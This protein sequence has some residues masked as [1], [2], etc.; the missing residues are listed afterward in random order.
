MAISATA[1]GKQSTVT[2][3]SVA[4]STTSAVSSS[5]QTTTVGNAAL[6]EDMFSISTLAYPVTEVSQEDS[7][8]VLS[9]LLGSYIDDSP[10][11]VDEY[12]YVKVYQ[13]ENGKFMFTWKSTAPSDYQPDYDISV[14]TVNSSKNAVLYID[15]PTTDI[16]DFMEPSE[17]VEVTQTGYDT[18]GHY[19]F[20]CNF[21]DG[22]S[23]NFRYIA[24]S[25]LQKMIDDYQAML[26]ARKA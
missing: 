10:I 17:D 12:Q 22:T 19:T 18:S 16:P 23:G 26:D 4:N 3:S 25:D 21:A 7:E 20:T 9:R 11:A 15:N 2:V 13:D 6:A 5:T 24:D 8:L 1:C 14:K